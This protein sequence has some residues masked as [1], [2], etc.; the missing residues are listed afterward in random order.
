MTT[1][2]S[3]KSAGQ[4]AVKATL[5][6][7]S[8]LT[9]MSGATI[10]PSLP[11]LYEH[12]AGTPHADLLTRLVLTAP[13]LSIVIVAPLAGIVIDR[14]GRRSLLLG[15]TVGYAIAGSAGLVLDTLYAILI[16]RVLLG[17][18]VACIMTCVMTLVG[19]YFAGEARA[20]YMGLQ[21]SFMS[22]GGVVFILLGGALAS[23]HWRGPFVV[24]VLALVLLPASGI[25]AI[26]A[27]APA[28]TGVGAAARRNAY[29]ADGADLWGG[30]AQHDVVLHDPG[31]AALLPDVLRHPRSG[32]GQRDD[33]ARDLCHGDD[34]CILRAAFARHLS[35]AAIYAVGFA[36]FGAGY[37]SHGHRRHL[38]RRDVRCHGGR[39]R[40]RHEHA[41]L[42]RCGCSRWRPWP[43]AGAYRGACRRA[44]FLGQFLSP[45]AA[46]P[47]INSYGLTTA[48]GVAAV[49]LAALSLAFMVGVVTRAPILGRT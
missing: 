28:G 43:Y 21:A 9:V 17:V 5:L 32:A 49:V 42:F 8:A 23:V 11:A 3:G 38:C 33:V 29:A 24:Y 44:F 40:H 7:A 4:F 30:V 34:G 18:A 15:A 27:G 48:Y 39:H 20:R 13:A 46:Q 1:E 6:A 12:F 2:P 35:H 25:A 37:A 19:D 14:F 10:A 26:R 16:S 45:L 47:V 36:F 22:F 41:Q 31:T